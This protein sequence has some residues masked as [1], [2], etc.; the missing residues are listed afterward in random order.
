MS[1]H[2]NDSNR[3]EAGEASYEASFSM[4]TEG[5]GEARDANPRKEKRR[6]PQGVQKINRKGK[7][8]GF[9]V[10][11]PTSRSMRFVYPTLHP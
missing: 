10:F 2:S 1:L 5:E 9:K 7:A 11:E 6:K 3:A 4:E 8:I